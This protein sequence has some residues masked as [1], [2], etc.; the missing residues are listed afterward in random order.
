MLAFAKKKII[1]QR[2]C[3]VVFWKGYLPV[4]CKLGYLGKTINKSGIRE[5]GV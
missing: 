3:V 5:I 4:R 1:N 2:K